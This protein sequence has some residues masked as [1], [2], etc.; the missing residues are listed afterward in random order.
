MS[1]MINSTYSHWEKVMEPSIR[2]AVVEDNA[3]QRTILIRL[4]ESSYQVSAYADG[5]SFLQD[6]TPCDAVLLDIEMPGLS[7][8]D[9]CR[10][11]RSSTKSF[12]NV[13]VIFV[14]A[15]DEP[16][17]RVAAYEA[18]GDDFITKPIA[19]HELRHK[20]GTILEQRKRIQ[21]LATQNTTV[22]QLAMTAMSSISD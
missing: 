8:Y 13:P 5:D 4:L 2:I 7:G 19:A 9:T 14:S 12:A 15:H 16:N 11:L 1:I 20:L 10:Q 18:G 17:E 6:M 21:E 22:Q 3:T